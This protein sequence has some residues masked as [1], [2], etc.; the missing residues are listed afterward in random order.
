ML[1]TCVTRPWQWALCDLSTLTS[2]CIIRLSFQFLNV[3]CFLSSSIVQIFWLKRCC[4]FLRH[5]DLHIF[6]RGELLL[7]L[8]V[9]CRFLSEI[10]SPSFLQWK[11]SYSKLSEHTVLLYYRAS[12][13]LTVIVYLTIYLPKYKQ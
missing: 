13:K 12:L 3:P 9:H 11:P 4:L 7:T 8:S 5:S 2:L 1:G 10:L 6:F